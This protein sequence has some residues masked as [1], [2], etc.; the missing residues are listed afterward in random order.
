MGF[1]KTD[2][3]EKHLHD[4]FNELDA[5]GSEKLS[6]SEF[7]MLLEGLGVVF[8]GKKWAQVFREIDRN[9][10]DEVISMLNYNIYIMY[11][12]EDI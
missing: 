1:S 12:Y 6:R 11:F 7:R 5:D 3:L 10:D 9:F 2:N 4:I 8:S